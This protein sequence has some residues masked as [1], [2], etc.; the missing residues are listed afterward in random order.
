MISRICARCNNT[1][2][3]YNEDVTYSTILWCKVLMYFFSR[4]ALQ[5]LFPKLVFCN[6]LP[7]FGGVTSYISIRL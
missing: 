5:D 1:V 7:A 2:G 3:Y 6:S 4:F